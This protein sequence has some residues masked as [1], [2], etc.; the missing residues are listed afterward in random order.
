L[1]QLTFNSIHDA[2]ERKI[3]RLVIAANT[4][5]S[6]GNLLPQTRDYDSDAFRNRGMAFLVD[7]RLNLGASQKHVGR[8]KLFETRGFVRNTH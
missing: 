8:W 6:R 1:S 4:D 3:E 7:Q 2:V 5:S